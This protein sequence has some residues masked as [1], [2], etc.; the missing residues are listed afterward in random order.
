MS[1][2]GELFHHVAVDDGP[3]CGGNLTPERPSSE[4]GELTLH[5][6][7]DIALRGILHGIERLDLEFTFAVWSRNIEFELSSKPLGAGNR[8]DTTMLIPLTFDL[9]LDTLRGVEDAGIV[10][11]M[12]L[13]GVC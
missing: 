9:H 12:V 8:S 10:S 3:K 11:T 4:R 5:G 6:L 13:C 1:R 2:G 7:A